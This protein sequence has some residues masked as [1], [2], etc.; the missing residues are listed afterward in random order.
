MFKHTLFL[1]IASFIGVN[2]FAQYAGYQPG[3]T[4]SMHGSGV[5]QAL[6]NNSVGGIT[7]SYERLKVMTGIDEFQGSPYLEDKF[8]ATE[9]Y[10]GDEDQGKIYYRYN[11][12]N[13][14]IEIKNST[15][16][17]EAPRS[18]NK[19]KAIAVML[20]NKYPL[21]FSTFIDAKDNTLNGYLALLNEG[22]N[23]KLF[24]RVRVKFTEG[25]KAQNSFVSAIPNRFT[26]YIEYYYQPKGVNRI[27]E[28]PTKNKKLIKMLDAPFKEK[29]SKYLEENELNIKEEAD[30]IKAFEFL[31]S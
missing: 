29:L 10:Y 12:Y 13:E 20:D 15:L 3:G 6:L 19:D 11:A 25:Q 26:H 30:L 9:M 16:A 2:G 31:N 7:D 23:F 4:G 14:E 17:D 24:R 28:I 18:L 5:S 1:L 27:D 22:D 8:Q 21:S